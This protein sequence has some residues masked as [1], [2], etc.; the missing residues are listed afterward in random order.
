MVLIYVTCKNIKMFT[1]KMITLSED[2][3]WNSKQNIPPLSKHIVQN[4]YESYWIMS[5][6]YTNGIP[7][8]QLIGLYGRV[9]TPQ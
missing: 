8:S 1:F 7:F 9:N 4:Y 3:Y 2:L 5:G 6:L